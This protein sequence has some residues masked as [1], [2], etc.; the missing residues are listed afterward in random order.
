MCPFCQG[1]GWV[2]KATPRAL[3]VVAHPGR[4]L[5]LGWLLPALFAGIVWGAALRTGVAG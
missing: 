3:E 4:F 2:F 1:W 5:A